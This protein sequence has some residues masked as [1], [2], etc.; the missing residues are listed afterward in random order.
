MIQ[1]LE[2]T[3]DFKIVI[4]IVFCEVKSFWNKQKTGILSREV[5]AILNI[6]ETEKFNKNITSEIRNSLKGST[7]L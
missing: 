2:L 3:K 5:E 1:I 6:K 7:A 4:I